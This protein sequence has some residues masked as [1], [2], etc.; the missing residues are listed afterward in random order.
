MARFEQ[1]RG[2]PSVGVT[3]ELTVSQSVSQ[4]GQSVSVDGDAGASAFGLKHHRDS[5]YWPELVVAAVPS[6]LAR[7][8]KPVATAECGVLATSFLLTP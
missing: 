3:P 1:R 4:V 5:R 6:S 7:Q 2:R 8:R